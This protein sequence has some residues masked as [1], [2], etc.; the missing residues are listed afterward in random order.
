[1][2]IERREFLSNC[3]VAAA[4]LGAAVPAAAVSAPLPREA[5]QDQARPQ[6]APP[7]RKY[8]ISIEI[9]ESKRGKCA[10]HEVGQK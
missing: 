6:Q 10:Q 4:A 9:V 1:M 5:G 7:R 8:Q 3:G 2:K